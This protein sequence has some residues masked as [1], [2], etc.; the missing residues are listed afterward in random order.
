MKIDFHHG[1]VKKLAELSGFTTT[2]S[3]IIAYASQY[4]DE[5]DENNKMLINDLPDEIKK[6]SL[7]KDR[8]FQPIRTAHKNF[9]QY[10]KNIP[11]S[12]E[13][14]WV[15]VP[16]HFIPNIFIPENKEWIV[17]K[18]NELALRLVNDAIDA[19][20]RS[21]S[22]A[23]RCRALIK[24]G[25]SL[26]SYADTWA[27]HNFSGI[28]SN[29]NKVSEFKVKMSND[30]DWKDQ[31]IDDTLG[32]LVPIGHAGVGEYPD[33]IDAQMIYKKHNGVM[34]DSDDGYYKKRSQS[35]LEEFKQAAE[36]IFTHLKK[37]LG[38]EVKIT[39]DEKHKIEKML[40]SPE[41]II[42]DENE[43]K[44]SAIITENDAH[45]YNG[46]MKWFYFHLEAFIQQNFIQ[47]SLKSFV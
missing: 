34:S 38:A 37:A 8:K 13:H 14:K 3:E 9:W 6:T 40:L 47:S 28:N 2:D 11:F 39:A 44:N 17:T 30:L 41:K 36:H 35:N 26:H 18:N 24:F 7:Y 31:I 46:D 27:H 15:Y 33:F 19:L 43:W 25:I 5:A 4:V 29:I 16:F 23:E 45:Y 21:D 12:E 20:K 1:V 42:H 32:L 10:F 22:G